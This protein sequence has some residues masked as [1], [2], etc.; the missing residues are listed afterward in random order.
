MV[1]LYCNAKGCDHLTPLSVP[2]AG[3]IPVFRCRP[4]TPLGPKVQEAIAATL[5]APAGRGEEEVAKHKGHLAICGLPVYPRE[6]LM[7]A[8]S[9]HNDCKAELRGLP[10]PP[11][12]I[13]PLAVGR[14]RIAVLEARC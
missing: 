7:F 10:L 2:N 4:I 3:L 8:L 1:T 14:P 6:W 5:R 13:G 12:V 9:S 11:G